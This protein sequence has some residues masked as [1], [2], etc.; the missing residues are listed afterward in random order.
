MKIGISKFFDFLESFLRKNFKKI[1]FV[2]QQ[3]KV[4]IFVISMNEYTLCFCK[5]YVK[6]I[7][8]IVKKS[9]WL[10]H[11]L[12]FTNVNNLYDPSVYL[13]KQELHNRKYTLV[14]DTNIYRYLL[15]SAKNKN[16]DEK[17]HRESVA[18]L[19]FCQLSGIE[20]Y[21]LFAVIERLNENSLDP[22]LNDLELLNRLNNSN[23]D[24]LAIYAL[25]K[26]ESIELND[27]IYFHLEETKQK[28]IR[29]KKQDEWNSLYLMALKICEIY[30]N[31]SLAHKDKLFLYVK[32]SL[33]D[34]RMGVPAIVFALV[35]FGKKPEKGMM[36]YKPNDASSVKKK[37]IENMTWDLFFVRNF[38]IMWTEKRDNQEFIF[39]SNDNALKTVLRLS[40][41]VYQNNSFEPCR[42]F[43]RELEFKELQKLFDIKNH[44]TNRAYKNPDRTPENWC[45]HRKKLILELENKLLR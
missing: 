17:L 4:F 34:F 40:I 39:A 44:G 41:Q 18:L 13:C 22:T 9:D 19:I 32:W 14:I 20:I 30:S 7:I 6:E 31:N 27:D 35:I 37:K 16:P 42:S 12:N 15:N 43:V 3:I 24:L 25:G 2:N 33:E 36:K 38:F 28:L 10:I 23:A 1:R 8:Y 45:I 5:K 29:Y 11:V 21:P 26:S